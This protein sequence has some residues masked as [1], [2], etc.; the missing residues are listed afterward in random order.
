M[1]VCERV[2]VVH[3]PTP[4]MEA[5]LPASSV[6]SWLWSSTRSLLR[7][8]RSSS[9]VRRSIRLCEAVP[10]D[11]L[12]LCGHTRVQHTHTHTSPLT[13]QHT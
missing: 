4:Q 12:T 5:L 11:G 13:H 1:R 9:D 7:P 2:D 3:V 10:S 8:R 6:V